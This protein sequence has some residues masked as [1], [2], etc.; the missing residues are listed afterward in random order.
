VNRS[1]ELCVNVVSKAVSMEGIMA[2][3]LFRA[4]PPAQLGFFPH[5]SVDALRNP[6]KN[7]VRRFATTL[8]ALQKM[9]TTMA[10][11][12]HGSARHQSVK[13]ISRALR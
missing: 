11:L 10:M 6:F 8:Y 2:S 7:H 13:S 9:S 3:A 4:R 12:N 5:G 1:V